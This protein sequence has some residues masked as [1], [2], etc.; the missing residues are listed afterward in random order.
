MPFRIDSVS[1]CTYNC[2]YCFAKLRG[3]FRSPNT[4]FLDTEELQKRF[5]NNSGSGIINELLSSK[6]PLHFGGMSDPNCNQFVSDKTLL[7]LDILANKNYPVIVSTKNPERF[8]FSE[9]NISNS[10]I[11]QVSF[12]TINPRLSKELEPGAPSPQ[13]RIKAIKALVEKG[14][15]IT[16][17]IQPFFYC[18]KE[19]IFESLIPYLIQVGVDHII[20]EENINFI[21]EKYI[22]KKM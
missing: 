5:S 8:L 2:Q 11:I 9:R 4:H 10:T 3:G 16:A 17:R 1:K 19:E 18:L 20:F 22:V 12:S 15:R 13:N 7:S 6:M 14:Y 21:L